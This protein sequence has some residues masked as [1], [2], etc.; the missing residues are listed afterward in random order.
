MNILG[1]SVVNLNFNCVDIL[2]NYIFK[3]NLPQDLPQDKKNWKEYVKEPMGDCPE[4]MLSNNNK[5]LFPKKITAI[6]IAKFMYMAVSFDAKDLLKAL[7]DN[8]TFVNGSLIRSVDDVEEWRSIF[9]PINNE[10][11]RNEAKC[12]AKKILQLLG[13]NIENFLST[14][15][16]EEIFAAN[17][18]IVNINSGSDDNDGGYGSYSDG[19][20]DDDGGFQDLEKPNGNPEKNTKGKP[21]E[22]PNGNT[23]E[24]PE[25]IAEKIANII[26]NKE[27]LKRKKEQLKIQEE[28]LKI[29][30]EILR[31]QKK[32]DKINNTLD[33]LFGISGEVNEWFNAAANPDADFNAIYIKIYK[34]VNSLYVLPENENEKDKI[35]KR[36]IYSKMCRQITLQDG[37]FRESR[38]NNILHLAVSFANKNLVKFLKKYLLLYGLSLNLQN[39]KAVNVNKITY[40]NLQN[41]L[42]KWHKYK[43]LKTTRNET[44]L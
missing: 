2:K 36:L 8:L 37:T 24:K 41:N 38:G 35:L 22:K 16:I 1:I 14:A 12:N 15:K 3:N 32:I 44:P 7:D 30:E 21:K 9:L 17:P 26:N 5:A 10:K 20:N 28:I 33:T 25:E 39:L 40:G 19:S 23:K 34:K 29:Q 4:I 13:V 43:N 42:P 11:E 6:D 18:I 31:I 27:Q